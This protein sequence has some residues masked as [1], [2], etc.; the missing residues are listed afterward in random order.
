MLNFQTT[1]VF[2]FPMATK[3]PVFTHWLKTKSLKVPT[4]LISNLL[5]W[6]G[7]ISNTNNSEKFDEIFLALRY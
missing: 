7:G 2:D 3:C 6:E 4:C 5:F 1:V